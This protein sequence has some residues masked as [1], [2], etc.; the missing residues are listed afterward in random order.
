MQRSNLEQEIFIRFK[1][2][3]REFNLFNVLVAP[4]DD[5]PEQTRL[6]LVIAHPSLIVN[7]DVLN[8]KLKPYIEKVASKRGNYERIYKNT[9]LFLVATE[10]GINQLHIE[11]R[12]LIACN[13]IKT[14]YA[15]Q[16]SQEQKNDLL[17]KIKELN[18]KVDRSIC[19]AYSLIIKAGAKG[20]IEKL[21]I[22]QFK[23]IIDVQFNINILELL[24]DEEWLLEGVGF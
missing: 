23:E 16:L 4:S 8:G 13:K 17:E 14:D 1:V 7:A 22:K 12:E 24:K 2:H 18:K 3:E 6:T 19:I 11:L 5:L 9:I 10:M 15:G 21:Q 20:E